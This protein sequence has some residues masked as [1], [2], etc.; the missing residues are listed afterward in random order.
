MAGYRG[1]AT[2]LWTS[3]KFSERDFNP[4]S[5]DGDDLFT[6]RSAA[7]MHVSATWSNCRVHEMNTLKSQA[8]FEIFWPLG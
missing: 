8:R 7:A 4:S 3:A 2:F 6:E 5:A 1:N